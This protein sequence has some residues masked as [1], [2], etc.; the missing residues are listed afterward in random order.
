MMSVKSVVATCHQ[1]SMGANDG[2][3]ICE[4]VGLCMQKSMKTLISP[5]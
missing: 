4:L 1:M 2:T 3:E 5:V